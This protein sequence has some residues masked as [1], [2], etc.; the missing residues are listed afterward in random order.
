ML[1]PMNA[2]ST[3]VASAGRQLGRRRGRDMGW[4]TGVGDDAVPT[5][6]KGFPGQHGPDPGVGVGKALGCPQFACWAD[7]HAV[8]GLRIPGFS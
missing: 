4:Q 7:G 3:D 8:A 1:S 2:H 5:F 6:L